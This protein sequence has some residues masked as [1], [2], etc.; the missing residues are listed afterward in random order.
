MIE[1][2]ASDDN[3]FTVDESSIT[4]EKSMHLKYI[5][6]IFKTLIFIGKLS[7]LILIAF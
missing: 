1:L 2:L 3:F 4:T 6:I 5:F 7:C